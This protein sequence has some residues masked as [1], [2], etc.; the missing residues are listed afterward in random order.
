MLCCGI[1]ALAKP[2]WSRCGCHLLRYCRQPDSC[3]RASIRDD[4]ALFVIEPIQV[5]D[6][7]LREDARDEESIFELGMNAS[8]G[9]EVCACDLLLAKIT[10]VVEVFLGDVAVPFGGI[11]VCYSCGDGGGDHGGLQA[12]E[13]VTDDAEDVGDSL[14]AMYEKMLSRG[15]TVRGEPLY[16]VASRKEP[17]RTAIPASCA[18]ANLA[19]FS[20]FEARMVM[21]SK[22]SFCLMSS[23]KRGLPKAPPAPIRRTETGRPSFT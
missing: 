17:V 2:Q 1:Y 6:R 5:K 14:G 8:L 18:D 11:E 13:G 22:E 19:A 15:R 7:P 20:S 9:G 4:F 3:I 16:E 23:C 21:C 10:H 12:E